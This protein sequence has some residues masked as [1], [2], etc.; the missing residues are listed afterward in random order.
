VVIRLGPPEATCLVVTAR[1]GVF[2]S[3][4]HDLELAVTR[5]D[6]RVDE[7]ERRVDASFDAA[8]LRV[9][10]AF[11]AGKPAALS[12]ADRRTIEDNARKE[13]L[14]S[15]RHPEIRYRSTRVVDA[16]Q[17]FDVAGRLTVR[18]EEREVFVALRRAGD[19]YATSVTLDQRAFGITPYAVMLGALRVKPEI[20]VRLSL[21][22]VA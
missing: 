13:V 22:A 2:A 21:P 18:G 10:Q 1:E 9:V 5:F 14:A 7:V 11:R 8:S 6:I 12:D 19:R 16:P 15:N 4:G 3:L 17:G 20:V